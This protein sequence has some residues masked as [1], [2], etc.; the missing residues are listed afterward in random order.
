M[1]DIEIIAY[2]I[3]TLADRF[4]KTIDRDEQ[5]EIYNEVKDAA[6]SITP[7]CSKIKQCIRDIRHMMEVKGDK[8]TPA[9]SMYAMQCCKINEDR[10]ETVVKL[11]MTAQ[12]TFQDAFDNHHKAQIGRVVEAV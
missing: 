11:I 7:Y 12:N 2:N 8:F 6:G 9:E 3:K 5:Q 10:Q 1:N 4:N